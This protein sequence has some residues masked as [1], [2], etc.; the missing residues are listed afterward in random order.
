[1]NVKYHK[2]QFTDNET[3]I[4]LLYGKVEAGLWR[5][6]VRDTNTNGSPRSVGPL[7]PTKETLLADLSRYATEYG[8]R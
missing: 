2:T 5:I 4:E 3:A 1:M 6:F 7:Y 8:F